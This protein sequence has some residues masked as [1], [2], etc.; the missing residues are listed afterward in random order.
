MEPLGRPARDMAL[1][2]DPILA[3]PCDINVTADSWF[4]TS[5]IAPTREARTCAD[6]EAEAG[7]GADRAVDMDEDDEGTPEA[8]LADAS[9]APRRELVSKSCSSPLLSSPLVT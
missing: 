5:P 9:W 3:V 4:S 7:V 8:G 2:V 1:L 6:E